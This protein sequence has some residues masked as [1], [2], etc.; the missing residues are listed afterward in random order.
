MIYNNKTVR[1][2]DR[3]LNEHRAVELLQNNEFGILSMIDDNGLPYAIP[4]NFVWDKKNAIYIHCAMDGKKINALLKNTNVSFCIVGDVNLLSN[5]FTTEY[6][7][8]IVKGKVE[9]NISDNE[10]N[11][12]IELLLAKF[13]PNDLVIGRKYAEKSFYRTRIIRIDVT[14]FS[15]KTKRI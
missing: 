6:E 14:E 3:L 15:G 4:I 10:K 9:L 8:V 11:M 5:K 7:S 13:S 1:R 12:A 2:Q